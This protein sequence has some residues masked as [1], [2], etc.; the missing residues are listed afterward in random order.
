MSRQLHLHLLFCLV[1][2]YFYSRKAHGFHIELNRNTLFHGWWILLY[3]TGQVV[4]TQ[5]IAEQMALLVLR[6]AAASC[7]LDA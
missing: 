4:V 2:G 1:I 6:I 5:D 7:A 3:L